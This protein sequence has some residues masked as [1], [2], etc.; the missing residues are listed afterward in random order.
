M[1][2]HRSRPH[3][4]IQTE[5]VVNR[6]NTVK[7]D[8]LTLQ[9]DR[10]SWRRS[11]DGCRVTVYRHLN[12]TITLGFGPQEVGRYTADGRPLK[13][14]VSKIRDLKPTRARRSASKSPNRTFDVLIKQ[15]IFIC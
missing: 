1:H 15:D 7:Y 4:P 5:R 13:R 14:S 8:N 6:D 10:Q 3:I 12:G 11:M 2:P 9:I